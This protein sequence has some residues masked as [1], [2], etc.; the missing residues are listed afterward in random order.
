MTHVDNI[1]T[2]KNIFIHLLL[3]M[4]KINNN[5]EVETIINSHGRKCTS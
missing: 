2:Y 5:L 3:T 4:T 1:S